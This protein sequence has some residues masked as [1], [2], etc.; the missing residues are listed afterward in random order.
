MSNEPIRTLETSL[1]S[2]LKSLAREAEVVMLL[3]DTSASMGIALPNG[4]R[5]IDALREVV[6]DLALGAEVPMIA[7]GSIDGDEVCFV[8]D[9]PEP[10]GGTPLALAIATAKQYGA[11]RVVVISD[12][13]PN[14]SQAAF[15]QA[16]E[17]KGRIDVVFVGNADAH[18]SIVLNELA[19]RTGGTRLEGDL[20]Q[21]KALGS[22]IIGLLEGEVEPER[23]P[24]QGD[25]FATTAPGDDEDEDEEDDDADADDEDDE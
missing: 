25:S 10:A 5:R 11:N 20:G 8:H 9:V 2:S 21:P 4:K 1:E 3:I 14:D 23:A 16:D 22:A 7:F 19:R 18:G 15:M 24:L 12:G 13:E 17:F 6:R